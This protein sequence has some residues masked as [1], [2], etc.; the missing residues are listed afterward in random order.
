M[1]STLFGIQGTEDSATHSSIEDIDG[2]GRMDM[3]LHFN[4]EHVGAQ[5]GAIQ[6]SLTGQTTNGEQI[7][8]FD[9]IRTV[10]CKE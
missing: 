7:Q 2:D 3:L 8:G 9:S 10:G 5:C 4:T 6:V 1:N